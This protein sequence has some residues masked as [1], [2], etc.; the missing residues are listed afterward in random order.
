MEERSGNGLE[1]WW[2]CAERSG[3]NKIKNLHPAFKDYLYKINSV[4]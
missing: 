2:I 1:Q 3:N 4:P